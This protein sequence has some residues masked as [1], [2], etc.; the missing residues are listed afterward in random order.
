MNG[1][2]SNSMMGM[3]LGMGIGMFIVFFAIMIFYI[4]CYWKI[5]TKAGQA[6]WKIFIPI[7]NIYV[8]CKIGCC[9]KMFKYMIIDI[10]ICIGV[11]PIIFMVDN[12]AIATILTIVNVIT[13]ILLIPIGL[14]MMWRM[15]KRLGFGIGMFILSLILSFIAIPIMAFSKQQV[16]SEEEMNNKEVKG[17]ENL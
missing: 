3:A 8:C 16:L 15:V 7:Y 13:T 4:V 9:T 5:F 2:G 12:A 11:L 14:Y 17:M 1:L 6:G 10:L